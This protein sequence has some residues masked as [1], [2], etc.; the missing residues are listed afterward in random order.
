[1]T[2]P[3][4]AL[5][6]WTFQYAPVVDAL[7]RG[8]WIADWDATPENWR[9]AYRW[10]AVELDRHLAVRGIPP[11]DGAPIW[12]WHSCAT[13]DDAETVVG[14]AP[15]ATTAYW[16]FGSRDACRG[17]VRLEL[18]VPTTH[19][20]LSSYSR[21]NDILFEPIPEDEAGLAERRMMFEPPWLAH[22][23]DEIQ[24]VLPCIE[25]AWLRAMEPVVVPD[26]LRD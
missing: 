26:E 7:A 17:L 25:P 23:H 4:E 6:L 21:F 11:A 14:T 9:P 18:D 2:A 16:L 24:A 5:R 3:D 8:R 19:V 15:T 10:M 20:L 1:M 22:P 12:C 13:R